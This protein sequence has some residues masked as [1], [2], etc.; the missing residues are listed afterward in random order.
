[1][2]EQITMQKHDNDQLVA[3]LES[4]DTVTF[5]KRDYN[6]YKRMMENLSL[7]HI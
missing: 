7:I 3:E 6:A 2:S 5:G 4:A 1:M